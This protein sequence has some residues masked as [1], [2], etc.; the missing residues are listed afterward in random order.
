MNNLESRAKA[1][2]LGALE[3]DAEQARLAFLDEQCAADGPLRAEVEELL[4]HH[5]QV[6][7]FLQA[8]A[9]EPAATAR[10]DA[11]TAQERADDA[12]SEQREVDSE[13]AG[14][15]STDF[16]S[17]SEDPEHLGRL[18]AYEITE[19]VGH[20]GMGIVLKAH[21]TKLNRVVAVK[22]L[23]PELAANATARKRFLRE[24]RAVAAVS[25]DHVVT[26][27]AVEEGD[28]PY[29][30]MEF[31]DGQS[32]QQKIDCQGQLELKEILRIGRQVA[33]GLAAAHEQGL[34]HRDVKPSNILLING[35]ERVQITDFGLARAVD[36]ASIT[37]TGEV[38]GTPQYM[39]PEQAQGH[40]ID[41]R[42]DLFSLG[43]VLYAMC[44]GRSPFRAETTMASLRRVC[45]GTP[46]PIREVCPDIPQWLFEIIDRLLAKDPEDRFQAAAEV[47][48]LLSQYLAHIQDP[49]STPLPGVMKTV[50]RQNGHSR[51]NRWLMAGMALL[52][53]LVGVGLT[54]ATGVT[55]FTATVIRI[56][57]GEGTLVIEVDDP[58]V[59]VSIDG[60]QISISGAGVEELKL[61][62][63]QYQVRA[64]KDGKLVRLDQE[65]VTISRGGRQVVRVSLEQNSTGITS[66]NDKSAPSGAITQVS[67]FKEH[68]HVV[69]DMTFSA[70]G[71]RALSGGQDG[72]VYLWDV[73]Q[74]TLIQSFQLHSAGVTAVALS[75]DDRLAVSGD[76]RGHIHV[77]DAASGRSVRELVRKLK[78]HS[79]AV[80]SL[81]FSADSRR[82]LFAA[83]NKTVR[84]WDVEKGRELQTYHGTDRCRRADF[85]PDGETVLL[86]DGKT[87]IHWNPTEDKVL[88]RVLLDSEWGFVLTPDRRLLASQYSGLILLRH[89]DSGE[90]KAKLP[91]G[92]HPAYPKSIC[93]APDGRHIVSG[94]SDGTV[95]IYSLSSGKMTHR[96]ATDVNQVEPIAVSPDGRYVLGA[97]GRFYD[98]E[99]K[100]WPGSGDYAIRVWR[101]PKSVWRETDDSTP[102]ESPV[103]AP[104]PTID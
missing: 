36:D 57:T 44:T 48:D 22:V 70:D 87:L 43:S 52:A 63:G 54:E 46:R 77:W 72:K 40:P 13:A 59:K 29:L 14:D 49:L 88:R 27:F 6:G 1:I 80:I 67:R 16:L 56:V 82:L 47:S 60:D 23:A 69:E 86:I 74:G 102:A 26:T 99:T 76:R 96:F 31:I 28:L 12:A 37:R 92:D 103:V 78:G 64:T 58:T 4:R 2:F 98:P 11:S 93:F 73:R 83:D 95:S 19:V 15:V 30:V 75:R 62:P 17:P 89:T 20:G 81:T 65:L 97:S 21:D 18:G 35:I 3:I 84:L 51:R 34:I 32:L 61:R 101:L 41:A 100:K 10:L 94:N 5:Q 25:H 55:Q 104:A 33:A 79:E 9:L 45:D 85:L 71:T 24:A 38:T 50:R 42:T 68:T 39:S 91:L 90:L 8:P 66:S 7:T 53:V